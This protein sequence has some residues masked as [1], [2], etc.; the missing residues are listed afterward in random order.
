[1]KSKTNKKIAIVLFL[2]LAATTLSAKNYYQIKV[3]NVKDQNQ[4]SQVE[5]YLKNAYLP[6]LHKAG[7]K[8]V[9]VFKP[10]ETDAAAGTK[11]IVFIP[12]K[13]M[14]QIEDMEKALSKDSEYQKNGAE[15]INAAWDNPSFVRMESIL[16]RAFSEMPEFSIPKHGTKPS[17]KI[18]ELR[19]YEGPTEKLYRKKVEMFNKGGEVALFK[20]LDFQAVF[21]A[22]V[23]SGSTMPNLMYMTTFSDM[24][25]HDEHWNS[26]RNHP[27]WKELSG[28]AEYQ[29]TVSHS[30]IQ[31]LHPTDYSDI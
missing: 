22:E 30:V 20:K 3:Y 27:D 10:I 2:F 12:L 16:L 9:G 13:E 5:K 8:S 28:K 17:E 11:V 14:D 31:L 19:S 21:Y 29:H 18:Y 7:I 4:E 25:S 24:K 1:M 26:F 23:L 15:Y 6:A